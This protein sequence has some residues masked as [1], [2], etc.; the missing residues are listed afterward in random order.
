MATASAVV[1]VDLLAIERVLERAQPLLLPEDFELIKGLV[2]TLVRMSQLVRERGSSIVR[3]RRLFG[4]SGS[5]KSR[6]VVGPSA[7]TDP[8]TPASVSTTSSKDIETPPSSDVGSLS[9]TPTTAEMVTLTRATNRLKR[10]P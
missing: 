8:E 1:D 7:T 6:D 9:A 3:L 4:L 5:E 10:L 2:D